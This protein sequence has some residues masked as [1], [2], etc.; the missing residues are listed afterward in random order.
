MANHNEEYNKLIN[1]FMS[2]ANKN[3]DKSSRYCWF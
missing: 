1:S 2:W 3:D